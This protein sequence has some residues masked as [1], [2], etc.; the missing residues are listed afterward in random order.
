MNQTQQRT[1]NY[2]NDKNKKKK[3]KKTVT[4]S[5]EVHKKFCP[6]KPI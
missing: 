6:K 5:K 2:Q 4:E 3:G 1:Q